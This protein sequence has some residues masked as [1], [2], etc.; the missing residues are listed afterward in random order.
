MK[1]IKA[2][3]YVNHT[4]DEVVAEVERIKL[5]TA[6]R[7]DLI[8]SYLGIALIIAIVFAF[9]ASLA[10]VL[11]SADKPYSTGEWIAQVGSGIVAGA[12]MGLATAALF[13]FFL[14]KRM[15]N[16]IIDLTMLA[17]T[18]RSAEAADKAAQQHRARK[19]V[20][21]I[22]EDT[23]DLLRAFRR[24]EDSRKERAARAVP[25]DEMTLADAIGVTNAAQVGEFL[26]DPSTGVRERRSDYRQKKSE[27]TESTGGTSGKGK[28]R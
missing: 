27:G 18:K 7:S 13:G 6:R 10:L 5:R 20:A 9:V 1:K 4:S 11:Q 28:G 16:R 26:A 17:G 24:A 14:V 8:D 22:Q 3:D 15:K 19:A 21:E 12:A 23:D 25:E 2:S